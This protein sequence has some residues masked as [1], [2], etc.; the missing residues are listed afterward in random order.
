MKNGLSLI[1]CGILVSALVACGCLSPAAPAGQTPVGTALAPGS[2]PPGGESGQYVFTDTRGNADRPITVYTYR[3][4]AWNTSGPVLIVLH[5][6]GRSAAP[7]RDIWIP[8]ADRYSCLV[9]APEF[10]SENY[11]GDQWYIGGN[12]QDLQGNF[13]PEANWTYTAIEHLFDDVRSRTGA[14]ADT[15]LLFGHSAGAQFVH[16]LVT[17]LPGARSSRAVAA[18]AGLY[19]MPT[20]AVAYGF[21]LKG[22]PLPETDLKTVFSRK[23]IIMSGD[24]DTNANDSSLANFP[25]AEAQGSTRFTRAQNYF[26]T[27]EQEAARRNVTLNWEYRIVPGVGHDEAG[28]ARAAAVVLFEGS[29]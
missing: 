10:S 15:Y 3:P 4:A 6:A 11:P 9:V 25:A 26:A 20:Y 13:N 5:G 8:Y 1:L 29:L 22:S 2:P 17:F 18:N 28:M 23:L 14:R 27:A 7:S 24:R 19:A 12:L 16:R 21:G